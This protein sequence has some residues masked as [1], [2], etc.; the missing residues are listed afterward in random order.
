MPTDP[1]TYDYKR[2]GVIIG[3]AFPLGQTQAVVAYRYDTQTE[4][5]LFACKTI[6]LIEGPFPSRIYKSLQD[7][8][9]RKI[10]L[11]SN[12]ERVESNSLQSA[13]DWPI[14]I[15]GSLVGKISLIPFM[16]WL[17]VDVLYKREDDLLLTRVH[18]LGH[19]QDLWKFR[20]NDI[21]TL[22]ALSVEN[23]TD[24]PLHFFN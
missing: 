13:S 1:H 12:Q 22:H 24:P 23:I 11:G 6:P 14:S 8:L 16:H 7:N 21:D 18:Q 5:G 4:T 3:F 10:A 19:G 2:R 15:R 9:P 17:V 20:D